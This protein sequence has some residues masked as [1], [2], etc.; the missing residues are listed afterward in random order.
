MGQFCVAASLPQAPD[1]WAVLEWGGEYVIFDGATGAC[2]L[3]SEPAGAVFDAL[4]RSAPGRMDT[5]QICSAV[6][7]SDQDLASADDERAVIE[8]IVGLREAGLVQEADS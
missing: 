5:A 1:R 7:G 6:F 3:L 4:L 2:H 8:L